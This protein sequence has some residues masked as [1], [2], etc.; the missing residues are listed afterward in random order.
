MWGFIKSQ[1]EQLVVET[2][3]RTA[4]LA[5]WMQSFQWCTYRQNNSSNAIN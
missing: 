2:S 5:I 3:T 1:L 4:F